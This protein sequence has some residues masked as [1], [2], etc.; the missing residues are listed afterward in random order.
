MM[1]GSVFGQDILA[2]GLGAELTKQG[3]NDSDCPSCLVFEYPE[4]YTAVKTDIIYIKKHLILMGG[5][6]VSV[7]KLNSHRVPDFRTAP[8]IEFRQSPSIAISY[9]EKYFG[10]GL[11]LMA[12]VNFGKKSRF[13]LGP[14]FSSVIGRLL[15]ANK[16]Q[17][18]T[19][20]HYDSTSNSLVTDA[21]TEVV[22]KG[23]GT[24]HGRLFYRDVRIQAGFVQPIYK[25]FIT[26]FNFFY[27]PLE[28]ARWR[29]G[30]SFSV[31]YNFTR[32]QAGKHPSR[33]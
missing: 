28:Y 26:Q 13:Y 20:F 31:L 11:N 19:Y 22:T 9:E 18:Y 29:F 16:I 3:I 8:P 24:N 4:A 33:E 27:A 17:H 23:E 2:I 30:M 6:N 14:G 15:S 7:Q 21:K 5:V 25:N 32:E 12:G 1:P 10:L